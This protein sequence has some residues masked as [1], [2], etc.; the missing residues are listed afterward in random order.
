[1]Q[2]DI[3]LRNL[4]KIFCTFSMEYNS[5][6]PA[7]R[8]SVPYCSG[9]LLAWAMNLRTMQS[10]GGTEI[11]KTR[12]SEVEQQE[13]TEERTFLALRSDINDPTRDQQ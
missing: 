6:P 3:I 7:V 12:R 2:E 4:L 1:M 13:S 10:G 8:N 11:K 5:S 9:G